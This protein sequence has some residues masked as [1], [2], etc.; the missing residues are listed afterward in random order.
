MEAGGISY[1]I[2]DDVSGVAGNAA[3]AVAK[4]AGHVRTPLPPERKSSRAVSRRSWHAGQLNPLP[5]KNLLGIAPFLQAGTFW[6]HGSARTS[7]GGPF[8]AFKA[9]GVVHHQSGRARWFVF[10]SGSSRA[11]PGP[12]WPQQPAAKCLKKSGDAGCHAPGR[13]PDPGGGTIEAVRRGRFSNG[14]HQAASFEGRP[15]RML[16][17]ARIQLSGKRSMSSAMAGTPKSEISYSTGLKS[18][19]FFGIDQVPLLTHRFSS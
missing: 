8:G 6:A 19:W 5:C 16:R 12:G 14:E 9:G 13:L 2:R 1:G 18:L 15:C 10:V 4:V 3:C 7:A 11:R 17:A